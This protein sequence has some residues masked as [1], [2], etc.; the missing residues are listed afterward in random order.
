MEARDAAR[1]RGLCGFAG[2]E[3][4]LFSRA[5]D[6][7]HVVKRQG[8]WWRVLVVVLEGDAEERRGAGVRGG[9]RRRERREEVGGVGRDGRQRQLLRRARQ[10]VGRVEDRSSLPRQR[11]RQR[12]VRRAAHAAARPAERRR[13]R[14]RLR[15]PRRRQRR[16]LLRTLSFIQLSRLGAGRQGVDRRRRVRVPSCDPEAATAGHDPRGMSVGNALRGR[17]QG[18]RRRGECRGP[19]RHALPPRALRRQ[20]LCGGRQG[21]GARPRPDRSHGV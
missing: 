7:D 10:L 12:S 6:D 19:R 16:R 18:L 4:V 9:L 5:D 3:S 20:S 2:C 15:G 1:A 13:I 8:R 21:Q 14:L 11:R 17:L